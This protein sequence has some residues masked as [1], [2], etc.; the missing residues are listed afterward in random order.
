M[1]TLTI[2]TPAYNRAHTLPR[3]Y[4]S[5]CR[6][7]CKDFV[8]LVVDDGSTDNTTELVQEWQSRDNG[9]EIRYIYKKNGG[10]HTAHNT[11]YANMDTE[12]NTCIDSDDMLADGAV[13]MILEKW[14]EVREQGYAGIVGLDADISGH[15]IGKAFP[16]DLKETT[17]SGYYASGGAGDKKLVYRTDVINAYPEYPVFEGEKYVSLAYKYLLID[18][19]YKLAVL[20]EVLCNVEYQA[21]GSSRNMY[22][23]Y[24]NNPKGFAFWRTVKMQYPGSAK[25]LVMDCIHYCSSSQIAQNR[26]YI[27]ESPRKLLTVLCTPAGWAL[28]AWIKRN[29]K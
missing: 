22:R 5:L 1:P 10:M 28:T 7:N 11:A 2:F 25:R 29:A 27:K 26:N 20:N 4:E 15:V 3:T 19:D 6:Q 18:Q 24:W 23:Q 17:L 21:D 16:D 9:Y 12:L 13:K 14:D 8:W